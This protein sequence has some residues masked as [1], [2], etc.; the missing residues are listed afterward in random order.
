MKKYKKGDNVKVINNAKLCNFNKG[1][2][3]TIKMVDPD[4]VILKYYIENMNGVGQWATESE[5]TKLKPKTMY[6]VTDKQLY[7][8]GATVIIGVG[9]ALVLARLIYTK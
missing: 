1:E 2:I 8:L 6:E 4:N 9:I 3:V 7:I 5:I